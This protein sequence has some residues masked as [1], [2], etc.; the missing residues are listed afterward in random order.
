MKDFAVNISKAIAII[1]MVL[2]HTGFS[3]FGDQW[4]NMFHMPLFFFFAGYCFKRRY[5]KET[6]T[7][8]L[9][10]IKGL[11]I[12]FVKYSL[13]FLFFHN[14]F[15]WFNIYDEESFYNGIALHPFVLNDFLIR[16]FRIIT[17]MQCTERL[18]G[19]YWFLRSLFWASLFSFGIL[20]L[21]KS[22]ISC[23][24]W[25]GYF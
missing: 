19:G 5:L 14:V 12:P 20:K 8:I 16:A 6:Q 7:F 15:F 11:Y 1:L 24:F 21:I 17:S 4:I 10:R 25:G 3:T 22:R 18:L 2:A 13:I 23:F 9:R